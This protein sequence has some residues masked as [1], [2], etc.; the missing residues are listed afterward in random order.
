MSGEWHAALDRPAPA[1]RADR[2]ERLVEA[3]ALSDFERGLVNLCFLL[4]TEPD[5]GLAI[6]E[7][8]GDRHVGGVP[9]GVVHALLGTADWSATSPGG[10]LRRWRILETV[11]VAPRVQQRLR[12]ADAVVD[13][14]LGFVAIDARWVDLIVPVEP[15]EV[16]SPDLVAELA[17]LLARRDATGLSPLLAGEVDGGLA[18][19]AA[20]AAALGL[21]AYQLDAERLTAAGAST[22]ELQ[23]LWERDTAWAPS[24]LL[25]P[26]PQEPSAAAALAAF[27]SGLAAH[28]V[29]LG[30]APG[31]TRRNVERLSARSHPPRAALASWRTALGEAA[32]RKLNGSVERVASQ[33]D[34]PA[35]RIGAAAHGVRDA[36]E[37]S[38]SED[39]AARLL[40]RAGRDAARPRP[41]PLARVVEPR[42]SLEDLVVPPD[43]RTDLDAIVRHV[44]HAA[45]VFERWGFAQRSAAGTGL[46]ALFAG[47]SGTGKTFAAEAIAHALDLPL[48]VADFSQILSKWLGE[49]PK[50]VARLFDELDAG[51]AVLLIDEADGLLGRR[52]A[53]TDA[54]DRYSNAEVGFFLQRLELYR[55]LA[56]LTS[57]LKDAIDPAFLRRYRFVVEFPVPG[58]AERVAL[59]TKAFPAAAPV[60]GL[61]LEALARLPLTGGAIRNVA[62]NAAFEAAHA[63]QPI[64]A[65]HVRTALRAEYRKLERSTAELETGLAP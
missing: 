39:A 25:V 62:L 50:L 55:G 52:G 1:L 59:W 19:A 11:G 5:A 8:T 7:L 42:A 20:A 65:Q 26:A 61:D 17:T 49:T 63:E 56:I 18:G 13:A 34:L 41:G 21:K 57:N 14:L 44:R 6:A 36:I 46:T 51:G 60:R 12:L 4:E 22:A 15:A 29:V 54:H 33:F 28:V 40:W 24:V 32:T 58:P 38:G 45:T 35:E 16:A 2:L 64:Q 3:F 9:I 53:V 10:P 43:V 31:G 27:V 30:D 48:V 47:P 37:A 23:R